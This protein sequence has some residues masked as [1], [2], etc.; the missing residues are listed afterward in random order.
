MHRAFKLIAMLSLAL[1]AAP[2]ASAANWGPG[3]LY[4]SHPVGAFFGINDNATV[5]AALRF[6]KDD[7]AE[8]APDATIETE[9]GLAGA[10]LWDMVGGDNWGFGLA[11]GVRWTMLSPKDGDSDMSLLFSAALMGHW[12]PADMVSFWFGHGVTIDYYSPGAAGSD[13]RTN[14]YTEGANIAD[15]GFTVWIP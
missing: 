3:F 13:S 15:V 9:F 4:R 5:H 7:L 14:F 6:A 10:L 2:I 8:T 12:D 1:V 11:P